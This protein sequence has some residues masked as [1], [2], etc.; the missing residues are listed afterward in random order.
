LGGPPLSQR[1][2]DKLRRLGYNPSE[3][4]ETMLS[5]R[6][7]LPKD[8]ERAM[9]NRDDGSCIFLKTDREKDKNV[10]SIYD[11]RPALCRLYPFYFVPKGSRL[12]LKVIPC[13]SGL[14][15]P[16]GELV[17]EGFLARYLHEAATDLLAPTL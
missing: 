1:D 11:H 16:E 14:N 4:C 3:F 7:R 12:L 8:T 5:G 10:C 6:S 13:C 15:D 17:D 2:I 9:R